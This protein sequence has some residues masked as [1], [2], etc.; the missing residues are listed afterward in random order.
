MQYWRAFLLVLMAVR[1][2][3]GVTAS[4]L[5]W[6]QLS[7]KNG[8][9]Q[10]TVYAITSDQR[11]FIWLGTAEGLCRYDGHFF[12]TFT[13]STLANHS[14][15]D[16][17]FLNDTLL[18]VAGDK[19]LELFNTSTLKARAVKSMP[20]KWGGVHLV[21]AGNGA[22]YCVVDNEGILMIGAD[23]QGHHI[24]S[25]AQC[26]WLQNS[27]AVK[28]KNKLLVFSKGSEKYLEGDDAG[29]AERQLPYPVAGNPVMTGTTSMVFLTSQQG[30]MYLCRYDLQQ[31]AVVSMEG[32][33]LSDNNMFS[34]QMSYDA[35]GKKLYLVD[36]HYGL[37]VIDSSLHAE[38]YIPSE[39]MGLHASHDNVYLTN[40]I[41]GRTLWLSADVE[42]VLF[43]NLSGTPFA[44][45]QQHNAGSTIIKG[46]YTDGQKNVYGGV[47]LD[48]FRQFTSYGV[49]VGAARYG[50]RHYPKLDAFNSIEPVGDRVLIYSRFFF[51]YVP[52]AGGETNDLTESLFKELPPGTGRNNYYEARPSGPNTGILSYENLVYHFIAERENVLLNKL[53]TLPNSITAIGLVDSG[54]YFIGTENGLWHYDN[55]NMRQVPTFTGYYIKHINVVE[56]SMCVATSAGLFLTDLEGRVTKSWSMQNHKLLN[57][58]IYGTWRDKKDIW[59]SCNAGLF[60]IDLEKD[61]VFN[62]TADD[63]VQDNEF[64][65]KAFCFTNN[66]LLFGGVNGINE[67]LPKSTWFNLDSLN[68]YLVH[69]R[70]NDQP[71]AA[72]NEQIET[73]ELN[74]TQ[75]T[76]DLKFAAIAP[77]MSKYLK[78]R[79][80]LKGLETE[81][82]AADGA[83][84]ARYIALPPDPYIFEVQICGLEQ[85]ITRQLLTIKIAPPFWQTVWFRMLMMI[86]VVAAIYLI[87]KF[88][89]RQKEQKMRAEIEA[90]TKIQKERERISRDLH[91]NAGSL[92]TYMLMQL[93]DEKAAPNRT[94]EL[95]HAAR[96]LMN[97]LRETIW[98]LA[99]HPIT[100]YEFCDKLI[101]YAKKYVPVE[102]T[103]HKQLEKETLLPKESVLNMYRIC[104]EAFNNILKHS[105]ASHVAVFI[106][107]GESHRMKIQIADNGV[108]FN[109]ENNTADTQLGMRNI[110]SRSKEA[111]LEVAVVSSPGKGTSI[112]ITL[113]NSS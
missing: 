12:R 3:L 33:G 38:A 34:R 62:Y 77:S 49:A 26:T 109:P 44:Q 88:Y 51:G 113:G 103:F 53:H 82:H 105:K 84:N 98:T 70:V 63:G 31:R 58:T 65:S 78:Y 27:S 22:A 18:Q 66:M 2:A 87:V 68:A 6:Q 94:T 71:W 60:H 67:I 23:R 64:N 1:G 46:I 95:K 50:C 48:S 19:G 106:S 21:P 100:N 72:F 17:S 69:I 10:N 55:L 7:T 25:I 35:A 13:D 45:Y 104:Q 107:S 9:L 89:F 111:G 81:F 90:L 29:F 85:S 41:I 5:G 83:L 76:L 4:P 59:G 15:Y 101:T 112:T 97:T 108:G 86:L 93:D 80:R 32:I 8:L 16:L 11:G 37:I 75:N 99:E 57:N 92:V 96:T 102:V 40:T 43:T 28:Y 42:G 52:T 24:R 110:F 74:Y 61:T 39:Q 56:G 36:R 30:K 79:Y 91:D 54:N 47:L 73:I 14:I 20:F